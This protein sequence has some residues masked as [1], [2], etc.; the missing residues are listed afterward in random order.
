MSE[1]KK[2]KQYMVSGAIGFGLGALAYF[3]FGRYVDP[4]INRTLDRMVAVLS[5]VEYCK[6]LQ[7]KAEEMKYAVLEGFCYAALRRAETFIDT[8]EGQVRYFDGL[9]DEVTED[10]F[11]ENYKP[12]KDKLEKELERIYSNRKSISEF[13]QQMENGPIFED[14]KP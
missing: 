11:E 14:V 10:E 9:K 3:W 12:V 7:A 6:E 1:F 13:C 2:I 8:Y 4:K 5:S